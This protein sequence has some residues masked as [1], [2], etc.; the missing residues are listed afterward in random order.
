M[1]LDRASYMHAN[2]WSLLRPDSS[3][4][5]ELPVEVY[6]RVEDSSET[7]QGSESCTL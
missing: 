4:Q 7:K 1:P 3:L 2:W 6:W 5:E